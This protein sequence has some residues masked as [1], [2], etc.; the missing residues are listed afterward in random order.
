MDGERLDRALTALCAESSPL[1]RTRIKDLI[2]QGAVSIDGAPVHDPAHKVGTGRVIT[3]HLP[4]IEPSDLVPENIPL[5]IVYEDDLLLVLDKPAGLVV[6]PGAGHGQGTL[7]HALLHHCGSSL[8]GIGGVARPGIVH[9]LDR[10]TS[11]LMIAAKTDTAH[12]HLAAQLSSRTLSRTYRALVLGAPMPPAGKIETSIG[13]NPNHRLKMAAGVK[14]GR[15]A[16]TRYCTASSFGKDQTCT[17]V[18][19]TLET[20]RTHQIRVHMAHIRAPV[21]GDPLYGPQKTALRARLR[22]GG[23]DDDVID[24]ICAFSRQALHAVALGFIHPE[25]GKPMRFE[26]PLAPDMG[27]LIKI[28]K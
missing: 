11:G 10:E 22:K 6:H 28:L 5:N 15:A 14:D 2:L 12:R 19:C 4:E 16:V 3:V 21:I 13:R 9:R 20:G 1:S 24:H 17:L 27:E 25:N 7:V 26:S 23:Y 8:S 18:E